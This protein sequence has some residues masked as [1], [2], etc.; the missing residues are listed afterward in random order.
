MRGSHARLLSGAIYRRKY[1]D[2]FL[3]EV[4]R[5]SKELKLAKGNDGTDQGSVEHCDVGA[6]TAE[7]QIRIVEDQIRDAV[8]KGANILCGGKR[9]E[10]HHALSSLR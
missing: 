4:V 10:G 5:I 7:F 3:N 1:Y 9:I 2:I 8:Q 6:M